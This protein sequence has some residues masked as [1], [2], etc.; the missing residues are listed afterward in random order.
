[1]KNFIVLFCLFAV[2]SCGSGR[3][4]ISKELES[5]IKSNKWESIDLSR[6]GG[7]DWDR[8]CIFG[9]YSDNT[10][11]ERVLGFKWDLEKKTSI[12]SSD[13]V[14]VLAFVKDND[15]IAYIEHPRNLGDFAELSGRC[16]SRSNAVLVR[17]KQRKD[18]WVSLVSDK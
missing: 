4:E 16:F 15:I 8:V 1:M 17:K 7:P 12:F 5:Q 3:S 9:P 11:A 6:V 10:R 13:G 2:A 18:N 14:N